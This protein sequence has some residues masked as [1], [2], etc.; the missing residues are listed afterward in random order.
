M[1]S[2]WN[3]LRVVVSLVTVVSML[4]GMVPWSRIRPVTAAS[5]EEGESQVSQ[6]SFPQEETPFDPTFFVTIRT[7]AH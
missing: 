4:L 5:R 2:R 3:P 7:M 1:Q 6:P